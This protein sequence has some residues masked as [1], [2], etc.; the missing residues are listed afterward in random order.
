M[1]NL[2]KLFV[3][4]VIAAAAFTACQ[5]EMPVPAQQGEVQIRV[6]AVPQD[7]ANTDTRTY[8][9]ENKT[10]IWGTSESMKL[11]VKNGDNQKI[12]TSTPTDDFDGEEQATF[13]FTLDNL[14]EADSYTYMGLYPSSAAATN[15][16]VPANYKVNLPTTQNA[17]ASSYDP[18][19]YI[20]V[21]KPETFN[22]IRTEW[23]ASYRRA[24][25]L[26]KIT[27]KN[28]P[29]GVSIKRV[30]V[31][32][33]TGK[34]LAG[35]RHIDLTT[36]DSGDI[37]S[38][39][40][41]TESI[42]V[43]YETP[44]SGTNVDVWFT[45]WDVE[46]A[47][48]EKLIIDV[49]TT[50]QKCYTK[51]ITVPSG[52]T[53]KFQE[54][55]LNTLGANMS[56]ITPEEVTE[57]EDGNYLVLAKDGD[58]YFAL[59][60]A[61][62]GSSNDKI[63][64]V[65]YE[66]SLSAYNGDADLIWSVTKSGDSY[67]IANGSNKVGWASGNTA[68]FKPD[69][70]GWT[71]ANY[72]IDVT[73]NSTNSCYYATLNS[74]S[75]RKLQKN[76]SDLLFAFYTSSQ[77]DQLIFVPATVDNRT[78]VTLSFDEESMLATTT[79]VNSFTGQT[80]TADPNVTEITGSISYAM[81]GDAIGSINSSTGAVTLNGSVGTT[82]VTASFPGD[83]TYKPADASYTISVTS[84]TGPQYI[85]VS[86]V[87]EVVP[88]DYIIT[89]DNKY[90]LPSGSTSNSNPAVGDGINVADNKII[91]TV[92][93]EMV[94]TFAGNNTDG[95]TI[96]DGT[97][98][99][100]S[101]N[102]AQGI[103][104]TTTSTRKWKVSVDTDNGM[105]LQ[106][107]DGGTRYL[108][109]YNNGSWRYYSLG[110]NYTGELRLY[111][112]EDNRT[113]VTL[114][115]ANE[116]YNF[117]ENN[118]DSFTGQAVT[119][120]PEVSGITY[121]LSGAAIGSI[122]PSTGAV[123]L[124]GTAGEA[125]VTASFPGDDDYLPAVASYTIKVTAVPNDGSLEH[126][127]TVAEAKA[128][129]DD[130]G[131]DDVYVSG[132]IHQINNK[133]DAAHGTAVFWISDD[134][135]S[136]EF[137]AYSVYFL[138]NESW[139]DGNTQI[140]VG[141]E[142]ILYGKLKKYNSTYETASKEAYLYSL[143]G[144]TSESTPPTLTVTDV[145]GIPAKG[146]TDETTTVTIS[147]DDAWTATVTPDGTIV[148]EASIS[149]NTVTY[150]VA[151]NEGGARSGSI[152][153]S[154]SYEE[155]SFSKTITVSQEAN[156]SSTVTEYTATISFGSGS[157]ST[158][159]TGATVTGKDSQNNTWTVTTVGT[160][161]FTPNAAYAQVGSSSK[162]AT[163]ITFTTTLPETSTIKSMSA[164]FGGFNSTAGTINLKVGENTLGTGSLNGTTDVT[165]S[166]TS[167]AQG[168]VLAVTV[169]GIAKGV[170]VYNI[171]VTYEN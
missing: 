58:K 44:L 22:E 145:T 166:S 162:P 120:S 51:E 133:Y 155:R 47:A 98:I 38:G 39:G 9:N 111:K 101:T 151:E 138:E 161:S 2:F 122:T 132:I 144:V 73:W 70:D 35:A 37:Y 23:M 5:E 87:N 109:V 169:T 46:V 127:F 108:S 146:A 107:N 57:L 13:E 19:A 29:S 102:A 119:A 113:P 89:W 97:N 24:T 69:G 65:S 139:L 11:I 79:D 117:N 149:G 34:Y 8:I 40:G 85:L 168:T 1:K 83:E 63:A 103:S 74:D 61:T 76:S 80:V 158:S 160:T 121:S 126:P 86:T 92:V 27:L 93:D 71:T 77:K 54:G 26:N 30:K 156:P 41:R 170:K 49:Y 6:T 12:V 66:G 95:F 128:Y 55:Y 118:Y 163:S 105:L 45:S 7:F 20:M 32:V 141:D 67:I 64:A 60:A 96:S 18:A 78:A 116:S 152:I 110:S 21:T 48:S 10:I 106:G 165:V 136:N 137:E 4:A 140:A 94:W 82:T 75:T 157:G 31:T 59:K 91:N 150:S 112:L 25:A 100:H 154:L 99:L 62:A 131:S 143:N 42:E 148:T 114:S 159:I 81:T 125:T 129:I 130:E 28:V 142:V 135:E 17:T 15:N 53:I 50:D 72:L 56:G 3:P 164:K 171:N 16:N 123:V 88:G 36:G 84:A 90:Y 43:K 115:F 104:I 134:G 147:G 52:K 167:T 33:P 68:E 153:V 124:N 14:F